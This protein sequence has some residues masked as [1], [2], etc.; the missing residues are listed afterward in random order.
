M[1]SAPKFGDRG[2]DVRI[3]KV[4]QKVETEQLA[5]A[6]GHI[7]V[8]GEI[9]KDLKRVGK[10]AH[11]G[12][13]DASLGIGHGKY[14]V[15]HQRH[16]VGKNDL[17]RKACDEALHTVGKI[18]KGFLPAVDL[19]GNGLIADNG[20]GHQLRKKGDVKADVLRLFLNFGGAAVHVNGIRHGLEGK[21]GDAQRQCNAGKR[22]LKAQQIQVGDKEIQIFVNKQN[23]EIS[24]NGQDQTQTP[25]FGL[26]QSVDDQGHQVIE[27]DGTDHDKDKFTRAPG[28]ENKACHQQEQVSEPL[29]QQVVAQNDAG[30]EQEKKKIARKKHGTPPE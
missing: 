21:E 3:V 18:V 30:Q 25:Q 28:V 17:F 9:K 16:I 15:C 19:I 1:P 12:I 4:F 26:V 13:E 6:D 22:Q 24:G 20:A 2:G 14:G 11:P 29:S 5:Q 27:Q 7:R 8:A 23:A 10:S